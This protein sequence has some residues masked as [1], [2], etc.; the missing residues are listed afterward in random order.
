MVKKVLMILAGLVVLLLAVAYLLPRR[1]Q[2]QRSVRVAAA[3]DTIYPHLLSFTRFNTWSP[4]AK[5]DPD[6]TY[7]FTGPS[8][9]VGA[10]M[11]WSGDEKVGQGC[12]EIV[13]ATAPRRVVTTLD[14]GDEGT[15]QATFTLAEAEAGTEVTWS[16]ETDLGLNP[17]ARYMGLMMDGFIGPDY[18]RGLANL[19]EVV[20]QAADST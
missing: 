14:F 17:L 11:C 7:A 15:G 5:L 18:E 1:V 2:V 16:F 12:Q 19:K 13:E 20:E 8:E 3:A 9:G 6:A 10:K 4:W